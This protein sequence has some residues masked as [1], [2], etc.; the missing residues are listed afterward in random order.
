MKLQLILRKL[1]SAYMNAIRNCK[2]YEDIRKYCMQY[3][4]CYYVQNV[5][6]VSTKDF[7]ESEFITKS[8]E[9]FD[10][11]FYIL[12]FANEKYSIEENIAVLQGR[13]D[14]INEVLITNKHQ[15]NLEEEIPCGY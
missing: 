9:L 12:P 4:M 1:R 2:D 3:G 8:L 15:F 5:L 11:D 6:G 7:F 14:F 10:K 13:L